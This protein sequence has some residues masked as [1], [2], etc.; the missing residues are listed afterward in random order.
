LRNCLDALVVIAIA[1]RR[2]MPLAPSPALDNQE[3]Q[4]ERAFIFRSPEC[5]DGA[6]ALAR[7]EQVRAGNRGHALRQ[8]CGW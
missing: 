1:T 8:P 5:D 7:T 4:H 3:S 2:G 6:K